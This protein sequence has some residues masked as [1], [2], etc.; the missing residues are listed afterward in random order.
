MSTIVEAVQGAFSPTFATLFSILS[1]ILQMRKWLRMVKEPGQGH[2][3]Y[4]SKAG[5]QIRFLLSS[6]LPCLCGS[7]LPH[8]LSLLFASHSQCPAIQESENTTLSLH[9][10]SR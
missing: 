8:F 7:C 2:I 1:P 3:A 4:N 9:E 6:G 10:L 5:N